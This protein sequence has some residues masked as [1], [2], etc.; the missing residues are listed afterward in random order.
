[1]AAQQAGRGD[2]L[3]EKQEGRGGV[4]EDGKQGTT[5]DRAGLNLVY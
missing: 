1:M 4:V 5:E 2:T 3:R